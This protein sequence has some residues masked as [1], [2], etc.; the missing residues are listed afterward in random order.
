MGLFSPYNFRKDLYKKIE[1]LYTAQAQDYSIPAGEVQDIIRTKKGALA[2]ALMAEAQRF[3]EEGEETAGSAQF[4]LI[5]RPYIPDIV[6]KIGIIKSEVGMEPDEKTV[7]PR[8]RDMRELI[9]EQAHDPQ[10]RVKGNLETNGHDY[11]P[12][13]VQDPMACNKMI[14]NL[15]N[16]VERKMNLAYGSDRHF[17]GFDDICNGPD[18]IIDMI[19]SGKDEFKN[20]V[21]DCE[22]MHNLGAACL[23]VM[24]VPD[25]R[26]R[27]VIGQKSPIGGGHLTLY[28]LEDNLKTWRNMEFTPFYGH[29]FLSIR[30]LPKF[31]SEMD[32]MNGKKILASYN[33]KDAF[34]TFNGKHTKKEFKA[35]A[36]GVSVEF[37]KDDFS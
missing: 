36:E 2:N 33:S 26:Y 23:M 15:F 8:L 6:E 16:Y 5:K 13:F 31:G 22:D 28:V 37:A 35:F 20:V 32:A 4:L 27:C 21:F 30:S 24:G 25:F 10:N 1:R 34:A 17:L 3:W 14:V 18:Q 9:A 19:N 12:L 11:S 7:K 29:T